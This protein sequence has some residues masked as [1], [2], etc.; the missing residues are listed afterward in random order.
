MRTRAGT[1]AGLSLTGALACTLAL[2]SCQTDRHVRSPD[3][4]R[5]KTERHRP[6]HDDRPK[7]TLSQGPRRRAGVAHS[8][9]IDRIAL[10]PDGGG[11]LTRDAVGGT[12]L[13]PL[14]DGTREPVV[15]PIRS[16]QA[17]SLARSPDGWTIFCVDASGGAKIFTSDA[18]DKVVARGELP[19]F[20][21]LIE[22]YVLPGG[23]HVLAL[24]R[25]HSI[26]LLDVAGKELARLE[27]RKFRPVELRISADGKRAVA[28]IESRDTTATN[29]LEI[30]PLD[31]VFE[32]K[33]SIR[34]AGSPK[35]TT[36]TV[37]IGP[38][39][40]ALSPDGTRM[41]VV[42]KFNNTAW[43]VE[44][45][46]LRSDAQPTVFAVQA[47]GHTIPGVG[48]IAPTRLLAAANDGSVSWL[49]D[50]EGK[51]QHPR[52]APPAD[53]NTQLR[54]QAFGADHHIAGHG[55]W[56]Y[57]AD[58]SRGEH[59]FLGYRTL[60]ATSLAMSPDSQQLATVFPQGPV[61]IEPLGDEGPDGLTA[62]L[63]SDPMNA[64]FRVRFADAEHVIL[65]DGLGGVQ[66]VK[67]KTGE[68]VA[69]A[70]VNGSIRSVQLDAKRHLLLIDR[71]ST[72]NDSRL[73]E[74]DA[75]RGFRG[76]YI[77]ADQSYR[78]GLL[79]SGPPTHED[80]VLWTLDS[81]NR[82]R[83]YSLAELRSDLSVDEVKGK[84]IDLKPGQIA[85]LALDRNGRQYGI[86]WNGSQ[87]ELFVD[88]GQ[89][90]RS[91]SIS[92][93]SVSEI[94]PADDGKSFIAVHQRSGGMAIAVYD[95]ETLTEQWS[96]STGQFH[97]EVA[98]APDGKYVGVAAQ[99]GVVVRAAKSGES[100]HERCGLEF[101]ALGTAPSTAFSTVNQRT[102]CE[103]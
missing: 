89:H 38:S 41:A 15:V 57:V 48:F 5:D 100:V 84:A 51:S 37:E 83:Y 40:A 79:T 28:L 4:R 97:S 91:K 32:G 78:T 102:L 33:A 85:P 14:L 20:Q 55:S 39:T 29:K 95:S 52:T 17:F 61:L 50:V 93:G 62:R 19:P 73:F 18:A 7:S 81:G 42:Q 92:D 30:Q 82:L 86:R 63:P 13:W 58:A 80:A 8:G 43:D 96:L 69:E 12:R 70:G 36:S 72:V 3:G 87:M 88:L 34:R 59:R 76:P 103:P 65:V 25:D 90:V 27:E 31:I 54:V 64:V 71:H 53:F 22:G 23:K 99:T 101:E 68:Q 94:L 45:I 6:E 44:V 2:G 98:W 26:R 46:D 77:I 24:F 21:P 16:P 67:W 9:A 1:L 10:A 11:A 60:Q 66:L 74:F 75:K 56:L 49:I 47:Q 35:L